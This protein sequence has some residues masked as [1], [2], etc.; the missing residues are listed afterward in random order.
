[1]TTRTATAV[2]TAE[3]A[4]E[5]TEQEQLCEVF[6]ASH[7]T[8]VRSLPGR[9]F[10]MSD[11]LS[12]ARNAGFSIGLATKVL[13]RSFSSVNHHLHSR[14]LTMEDAKKLLGD[15]EKVRSLSPMLV[16]QSVIRLNYLLGTFKED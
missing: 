16:E 4:L 1:M 11:A 5:G 3:A 15:A 2:A 13:R 6:L 12:K 14:N 7:L 9:Q 8:R 10:R